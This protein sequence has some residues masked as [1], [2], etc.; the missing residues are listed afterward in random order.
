MYNHYYSP[1]SKTAPDCHNG[2]HNFALTSARSAHS[3]GVNVAL[4][5]G[6]VR[7]VSDGVNPTIWQG[8]GTRAGGEVIGEY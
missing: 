7:F 2:Y 6:V 3:G 4:A 8:L 1:N 5:D